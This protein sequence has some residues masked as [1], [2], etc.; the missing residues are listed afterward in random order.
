MRENRL[1]LEKV[2]HDS[3]LETHLISGFKDLFA[4]DFSSFDEPEGNEESNSSPKP[5][6]DIKDKNG[7]RPRQSGGFGVSSAVTAREKG[8]QRARTPLNTWPA[9]P[10]EKRSGSCNTTI[11]RDI[12]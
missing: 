12:A 4:L 2:Y 6:H 3:C 11:Y 1:Y 10:A 7:K 5:I 9:Q 8:A